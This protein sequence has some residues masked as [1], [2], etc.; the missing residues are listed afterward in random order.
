MRTNGRTAQSID[1]HN[2][3]EAFRSIPLIDMDQQAGRTLQFWRDW[4][5]HTEY[6]SY[7]DEV[8]VENKWGEIA[9]LP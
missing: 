4:V 3:T 8:N 5:T 6:D 9:A 7:W 1:Y 2:W